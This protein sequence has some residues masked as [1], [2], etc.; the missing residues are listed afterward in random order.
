MPSRGAESLALDAA[1]EST[2]RYAKGEEK[3]LLDGVP[4]GVKDDLDVKGYVCHFGMRYDEGNKFFKESEESIWAVRMME[5]AGAVMVGK[6]AMHE[7]GV[8]ESRSVLTLCAVK[9]F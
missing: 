9:S 7:L 2:E 5:E 6:L 1:R 3:G 8:G 4:F